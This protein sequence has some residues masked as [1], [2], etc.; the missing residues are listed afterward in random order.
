MSSRPLRTKAGTPAI[1]SSMCCTVGRI[2]CCARRR[3]GGADVLRR[4]REV[5]QVRA[6]GVVE[7]QRPRER[8]EHG[9]GDT[10]RVAALEPGVVVDADAGE[11]RDLLAAQARDAPRAAP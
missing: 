2:R 6:L 4:A 5:E 7:L 1:A 8:L 10:A 11:Q 3:S 9:L